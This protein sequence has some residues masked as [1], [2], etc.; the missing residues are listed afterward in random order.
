[1]NQEHLENR[2]AKEKTL[3]LTEQGREREKPDTY[4]RGLTV[5]KH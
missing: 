2:A 3:T 4:R 5:I 1:M